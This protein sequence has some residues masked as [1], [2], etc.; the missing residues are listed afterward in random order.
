M[1]G[2]RKIVTE[3]GF[4]IHDKRSN[5]YPDYGWF[6]FLHETP[7][8]DSDKGKNRVKGTLKIGSAD[9]RVWGFTIKSER[10]QQ[11]QRVI[12][13]GVNFS[14]LFSHFFFFPYSKSLNFFQ[15]DPTQNGGQW[16][17]SGAFRVVVTYTEGDVVVAI[18]R[19]SGLTFCNVAIEISCSGKTLRRNIPVPL[20]LKNVDCHPML[21]IEKGLIFHMMQVQKHNFFFVFCF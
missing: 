7:I 12:L 16:V 3:K 21:Y 8:Q 1:E 6:F 15:L 10:E 20:H 11:Q 5:F 14:G 17:G 13:V 18:E 9:L 4:H 2:D 19:N